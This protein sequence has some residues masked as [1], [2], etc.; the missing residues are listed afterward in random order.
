MVQ[1]NEADVVITALG[2]TS[3]VGLN[4]EHTCASIRAGISRFTE[5]A[6]YGCL[7]S[8]PEWEEPEP[9]ISASVPTIDPFLDGPER[10]F[11]LII[12]ALNE[13][14]S[15]AKL[16]RK[17]MRAGGFLLAL[18]QADTVVNTWS[19]ESRFIP[20]LFR[21]T[22]L[23]SFK[24]LKVDQS[25]H[26]GMFKLI[27]DAVSMLVS[28]E[29]EFCVVGG[30]DSYLMDERLQFLDNSWR[31][32]SSRNADGFVPGEA[33][34]ALLLQTVSYTQAK[35]DGSLAKLSRVGL[36]SE[37]QSA[38]SDKNSSGQGLSEA[39]EGTLLEKGETRGIEWA[40]CDLNGESYRAFEWGLTQAK[41]YE[42]FSQ[43]K[44]ITHPADCLGDIGAATAG[45]LIASAVEAFRRDYSVSDNPLL[46]AGSDNG[47][48]AALR[49]SPCSN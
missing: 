39:I 10:L 31:I 9:L 37:P 30:V 38:D 22:G 19:L 15:A 40:L 42:T 26:A 47:L 21:R 13:L 6:Y 20:E 32:K 29:A 41:L 24:I 36:A 46:W 7:P 28:E 27:Q 12:P 34:V 2:V 48:R 11:H 35:G 45:V 33:G 17:E 5:H 14:F 4:T 3:P 23:N 25:G 1:H 16:K 43:L 18:P 44:Q 49:V 8:D